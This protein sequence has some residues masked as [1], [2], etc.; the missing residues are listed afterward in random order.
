MPDESCRSCGGDLRTHSNCEGCRKV[1]QKVCLACN[2]LTRKQYHQCLNH[3]PLLVQEG[4]CLMEMAQREMPPRQESRKQER[5]GRRSYDF[6]IV[7]ISAGIIAVLLVGVVT[8]SF[9][10]LFQSPSHDAKDANPESVPSPHVQASSGA[11]GT[12]Q[13][14][15][16]YGSGESVTVTCPTTY[17]YVYKAILEMPQGL[18]ARFSGSVFSIRGVSVTENQDNSVLLQYQNIT[19]LTTFFAS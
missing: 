1:I 8:D 11:Q 5:T 15:L 10:D 9:D 12:M 14:C 3:K 19:Y 7:A 17:G 2:A 18:A 4:P 6:R 16:A 13:N